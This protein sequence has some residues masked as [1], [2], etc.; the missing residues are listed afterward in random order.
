MCYSLLM[1]LQDRYK[2]T[3]TT[4]LNVLKNV[5]SSSEFDLIIIDSEPSNQVELLCKNIKTTTNTPVFLT[6]VYKS[7]IE[8]MDSSIRP[9]VTS[10]FYKPFDLN[11]ISTKLSSLTVWNKIYTLISEESHF[12]RYVDFFNNYKD[13]ISISNQHLIISKNC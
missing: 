11:E 4:D 9:Y 3:T 12:S 5:L 13:F 7:Q 8:A 6:Y 1:Y 2:V 10:I